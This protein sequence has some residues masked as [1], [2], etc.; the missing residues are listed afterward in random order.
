[1]KSYKLKIIFISIILLLA[2][3]ESKAQKKIKYGEVYD[4]VLD[5]DD[6]ISYALLLVYQRQN[7]EFANTYFQLGIIAHDKA[8]KYDPI[9]ETKNVNFFLYNAN[10]YYSLAKGKLKTEKK[11]NRHYYQNADIDIMSETKKYELTEV[12][13]YI[14]VQL[15]EIKIYKKNILKIA[16]YFNK[17]TDKYNKCVRIFMDVNKNYS[18]IKNIYLSNDV[19]L[20]NMLN[21]L[22]ITFDSC[23][24][25]FKNYKS[26]ISEFPIKNYKQ[27]YKLKKIITYRLDGLTKS[28]FLKND[29]TLWDYKTWIS[30]V[31]KVKNSDIKHNEQQ[32]SAVNEVYDNKMKQLKKG[33]YSDDYKP[34]ILDEKLIYKI[35]KY[36]HKSIMVN[37]LKHK[38]ATTDFLLKFRNTINDPKTPEKYNLRKRA[39]YYRSFIDKKINT[40][41]INEEFKRRIKPERIKKYGKFFDKEYGKING[42]KSY[43][44][45]QGIFLNNYL[46]LS[47]K[48]FLSVILYEKFKP[49]SDTI[50]LSFK[51]KTVPLSKIIPDYEAAVTKELYLSDY[52]K[53]SLEELY[54]TGYSKNKKG[55]ILSF[56]GFAKQGENIEFLEDINISKKTNDCALL[57]SAYDEGCFIV[58]VS[59]N[60]EEKKN[61]LLQIDKE[62]K[63]NL[64]NELPYNETPRFIK[65]DEINNK[66]IIVF[67]GN[68]FNTLNDNKTEQI[69]YNLDLNDENKSFTV[70]N[71][72]NGNI[73]DII[74]MDKNLF[75]FNNFTE[76]TK[77]DGTKIISG[78]GT[79][80][81]KTNIILSIINENGNIIKTI[82]FS[83]KR[84]YCGLKIIKLSS[85]I[86]NILGVE[87]EQISHKKNYLEKQRLYYSLINSEGKL[88]FNNQIDQK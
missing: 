48:N 46:E 10:L 43:I 33:N 76:Y 11:S 14:D 13:N 47:Y 42:L 67:K 26:A 28:N 3:C 41:S 5:G 24:Y 25:Y 73:I 12:A 62:G 87:A 84:A 1:M 74:K 78:A 80:K 53:N 29:I 37:F 68:N 81:T 71:R 4:A 56:V 18:K 70:K 31:K 44:N 38:K 72:I 9:T 34:I 20:K 88:L 30:D 79:G 77:Q 69:I 49:A 21:E 39:L 45:S 16:K 36:D 57:I 63:I 7:P 86:I 40:D 52:N 50:E 19:S 23:I 85:N 64:Q 82:A 2:F 83:R 55:K 59:E 51:N 27:E 75:V 35:E 17:C 66:L 60:E 32:I 8:Q 15:K 58:I 61:I 6:N 54:I 65:Y 22:E